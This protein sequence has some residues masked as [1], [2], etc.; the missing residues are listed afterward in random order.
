M[1]GVIPFKNKNNVAETTRGV[2][3]ALVK[4][5]A[6]G[7]MQQGVYEMVRLIPDDRV[8][9]V[10]RGC[11]RVAHS[12]GQFAKGWCRCCGFFSSSHHLSL[13]SCS[14]LIVKTLF[15]FNKPPVPCPKR[16]KLIY[17]CIWIWWT[18]DYDFHVSCCYCSITCVLNVVLF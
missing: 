1:A 12:L 13:H 7:V 16:K 6:K 2:R 10:N 5:S 18:W 15:L 14:L 3:V 17:P 8:S 4:Q 11:N 9:H